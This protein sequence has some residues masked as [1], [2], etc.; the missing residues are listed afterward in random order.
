MQ[1]AKKWRFPIVFYV[2]LLLFSSLPAQASVVTSTLRQNPAISIAVHNYPE[3]LEVSVELGSEWENQIVDAQR[4]V[5]IW[6][7]CFRLFRE[8]ISKRSTFR[9]NDSDF[10]GAVLLC[11]SGGE[12]HRVP[13]PQEYLTVGGKRDVM[14][15]DCESWTL[16]AGLPDWRGPAS[17]AERVAIIIFAKALVFLVM[18]YRKLRSW[19]SFLVV[20][21]ATQI[22]MSMGVYNMLVVDSDTL[23]SKTFVGVMIARIVVLFLAEIIPLVFLVNE[24]DKD[25]LA[26][27]VAAS[28]ILGCVIF[29]AT[30][31]FL[32][33]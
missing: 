24:H 28:Y 1:S 31:A 29:L 14:T 8:D 15:L 25:H 20:N 3:D 9:G 30:L 13:I 19:L 21:L 16:S 10:A 18:G 5:R 2:L 33:V 32:P 11:R 27:F 4:S 6:E 22:T 23:R 26:T 17:V 7:M 12:E